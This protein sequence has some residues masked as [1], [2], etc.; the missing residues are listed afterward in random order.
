VLRDLISLKGHGGGSTSGKSNSGSID[1][2]E[3]AT[4]GVPAVPKDVHGDP[5]TIALVILVPIA[6]FAVMFLAFMFYVK[7]Q[8]KKEGQR[9]EGNKALLEQ[10]ILK[11]MD[12][13]EAT[14]K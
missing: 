10:L 14:V 12:D 7:H 6:I 3:V 13:E 1:G 5:L 9:I 2:A 11:K 4:P 8:G